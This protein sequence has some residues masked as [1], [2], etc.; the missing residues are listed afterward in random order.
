[1]TEELQRILTPASK[2]AQEFLSLMEF[3]SDNA[4]SLIAFLKNTA[5]LYQKSAME[6]G[7]KVK[8]LS[9]YVYY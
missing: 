2:M 4:S 8:Q 3:Q 1:M 6:S 9:L 7:D 5:V